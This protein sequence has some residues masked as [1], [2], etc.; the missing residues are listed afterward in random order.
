MR[1]LDQARLRM[2]PHQ[3]RD[4]TTREIEHD[5]RGPER[6]RQSCGRMR[7]DTVQRCHHH[8]RHQRQIRR[9]SRRD[10]K[11]QRK[12]HVEKR[13]VIQRP[14]KKQQR[15]PRTVAAQIGPEEQRAEQVKP[16]HLR[17]GKQRRH[18]HG[19]RKH[20]ERRQP[21]QRHHARNA[22][23]QEMARILRCGVADHKP[24]NDEEQF[25]AKAGHAGPVAMEHHHRQGRDRAQHLQGIEP[26]CMSLIRFHRMGLP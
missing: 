8:Q 5:R 23:Q 13:L 1:H 20:T 11:A 10:R 26:R 25:H 3:P 12:H 16:R 15:H 7:C 21:V 19:Q 22:F 4:N 17:R 6:K 9:Q 18:D 2:M 24:R 14:A